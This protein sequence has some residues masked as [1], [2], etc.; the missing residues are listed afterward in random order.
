MKS[1]IFFLSLLVSLILSMSVS[2]AESSGGTSGVGGGGDGKLIR[3]IVLKVKRERMVNRIIYA[4][5]SQDEVDYST[6]KNRLY[7]YAVGTDQLEN[8]K[9]NAILQDMIAKGFLADLKTVKIVASKKCV[10]SSGVERTASAYMNKPGSDICFNP[11]R[12][13]DEFGPYIQDSDLV[14]LVMHEFAHHYGYEDTDHF[15]AAHV[16]MEYQKKSNNFLVPFNDSFFYR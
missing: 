3:S 11:D 12:I 14:G 16:A 15:F 4:F 5:T 9:A 1:K 7:G 13:V 8:P 6:L 2:A 10:D